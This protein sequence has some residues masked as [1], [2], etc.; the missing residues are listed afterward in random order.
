MP[1]PAHNADDLIDSKSDRSPASG[2]PESRQNV[3]KSVDKYVNHTIGGWPP[4]AYENGLRSFLPAG[5]LSELSGL[6]PNDPD[7]EKKL[8]ALMK[9]YEKEID[10]AKED[11]GDLD[12]E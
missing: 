4:A 5:F 7:Y 9:K 6:D 2:T 10:K 12:T 1:K 3:W 11:L 8:A